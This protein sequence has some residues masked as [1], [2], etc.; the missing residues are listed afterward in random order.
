MRNDKNGMWY[1]EHLPIAMRKLKMVEDAVVPVVMGTD[2][3]PAYRF[4]G[5]FE[6]PDLEY[7]TKAGLTPMQALVAATGT[8]ARNLKAEDQI[9]SLESGKWADFV[10][11]GANPLDDIKNTQKLDSVW[12][13]GNRVPNR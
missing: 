8:A 9:G 10:V 6:H 5:Y 7:M 4:Q 13:A 11:L 1:K 3:G 12:I 2:T